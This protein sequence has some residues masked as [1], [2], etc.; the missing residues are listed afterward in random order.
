MKRISLALSLFLAAA[1]AVGQ[2][3]CVAGSGVTCSP[4]LNLWLLPPHYQNWGVPWNANATAIDTLVGSVILKFPTTSQVINQP[5]LTYTNLN[6]LFVFGTPALIRFGATAG[7]QDGSLTRLGSGR[8]SL[9]SGSAGNGLGTLSLGGVSIGGSAGVSGQ[10]LSSDGTNYNTP[11]TCLT[12]ISGIFYQSVAFNGTLQTQQPVLNFLSPLTVTPGSG[13]TAVGI[14]TTGSEAKVVTAV[15]AGATGN[16]AKWLATGGVGDSGLSCTSS[17][18]PAPVCNSNGCYVLFPGGLIEQ[19]GSGTTPTNSCSGTS[20]S[21]PTSFT[22]TS[23]LSVT[24][25]AVGSASHFMTLASKGTTSF[26]AYSRDLSN[27]CDSGQDFD[28]HAIGQ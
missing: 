13:N 6:A 28:W 19:W 11:R 26:V 4:N 14:N 21:F 7:T 18:I 16:C 2:T 9:D 25:Q 1:G 20:F 10:C 12:D 3:G 8:F 15:A 5:S 27:D 17:S 22:T 23:N 24:L